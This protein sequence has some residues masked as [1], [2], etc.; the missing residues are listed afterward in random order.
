MA[1][2]QEIFKKFYLAKHNGRKLT[3]QNG[4]G[5][6]Q[7]KATF[8][9]SKKELSVSLVQAVIL[10]LF[11]KKQQITFTE[12]TEAGIGKSDVYKQLMYR[13]QGG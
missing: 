5:Q 9:A 7:V 12:I 13:S 6:C 2:Q 10:L 4:M 11:N 8:K 3:W 1:E